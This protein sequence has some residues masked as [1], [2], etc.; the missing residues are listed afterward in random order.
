[1]DEINIFLSQGYKYHANQVLGKMFFRS[2]G[3]TEIYC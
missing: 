2:I 3:I 1:M